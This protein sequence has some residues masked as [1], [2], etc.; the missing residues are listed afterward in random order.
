M[1]DNVNLIRKSGCGSFKC[2]YHYIKNCNIFCRERKLQYPTFHNCFFIVLFFNGFVFAEAR[3]YIFPRNALVFPVYNFCFPLYG[4]LS[5]LW[6]KASK[7]RNVPQCIREFMAAFVPL[8]K[9]AVLRNAK[10]K[11]FRILR[12]FFVFVCLLSSCLHVLES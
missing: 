12:T 3:A 9:F 4:K 10:T 5:L 2:F 8:L 6:R 7:L 1:A 11:S